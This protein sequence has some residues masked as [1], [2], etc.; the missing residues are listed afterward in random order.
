MPTEIFFRLSPEKRQNIIQGCME[1]IAEYGYENSSTNRMVQRIG[2]SKGSLFKYF[3]TKDDLILYLIDYLMNMVIAKVKN[4]INHYPQDLLERLKA[5]YISE[6]SIFMEQPLYSKFI[7]RVMQSSYF[8]IVQHM[9]KK[10][11]QK[12]ESMADIFIEGID[13]SLMK[14]EFVQHIR[15]LNLFFFGLFQEHLLE[16]S[17]SAPTEKDWQT[18]HGQ[19]EFLISSLRAGITLP[20]SSKAG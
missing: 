15:S 18:I 1:E 10:N 16:S 8:T 4:D 14:P 20:D 9:D 7:I 17:V 3:E 5:L 11:N 6:F 12:T 2:I 19:L 13:F